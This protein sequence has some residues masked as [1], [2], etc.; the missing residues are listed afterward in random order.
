MSARPS[1]R[2][3]VGSEVA[4]VE[5]GVADVAV[6]NATQITSRGTERNH[7]VDFGVARL[8]IDTRPIADANA[9]KAE[10]DV[11]D[12][13]VLWLTKLRNGSIAHHRTTDR[14]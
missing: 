13:R 12:C 1:L 8:V 10:R 5:R 3:V 9:L 7:L 2:P 11:A 14:F 4:S 6:V